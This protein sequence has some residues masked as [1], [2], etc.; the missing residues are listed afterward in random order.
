MSRKLEEEAFTK[1]ENKRR[2][3]ISK[4]LWT[5]NEKNQSLN[6]SMEVICH[7]FNE[8]EIYTTYPGRRSFG[9]FNPYVERMSNNNNNSGSGSVLDSSKSKKNNSNYSDNKGKREEEIL[10]NY[11]N[12]VSLPRGPNQVT[13]YE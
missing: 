2:K 3:I 4:S 13:R 11:E 8:N 12:M 10:E 7:E 1:E 6:E 9:G 5:N